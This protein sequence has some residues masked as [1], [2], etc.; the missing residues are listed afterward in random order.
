MLVGIRF[1]LFVVAYFGKMPWRGI[2]PSVILEANI[3]SIRFVIF[4]SF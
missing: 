2:N 3:L 1:W 4:R